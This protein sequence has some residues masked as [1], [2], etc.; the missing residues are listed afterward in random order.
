MSENKPVQYDG[1]YVLTTGG[2]KDFGEIKN[3][4]NLV[5]GKIRLRKGEHNK[6][7][8]RGYGEAHIERPERLTQLKQ[9]GYNSARDLIEYVAG[10]YNAVYQGK[11]KGIILARKKD[12]RRNSLV[13]I[14]LKPING[15]EFYD[16]TGGL[17]ANMRHFKTKTPLWEDP[18]RGGNTAKGDSKA[19]ATTPQHADSAPQVPTLGLQS[20]QLSPNSIK[21]STPRTIT[22]AP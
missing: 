12:D 6:E 22:I 2:N 19:D 7:T 18:T 5:D 16:V 14:E 17:V 4:S 9:N 11:D 3:I 10:K 21:K 15:N 1:E 13:Y 20:N 8:G